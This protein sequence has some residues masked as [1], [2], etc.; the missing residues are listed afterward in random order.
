MKSG[1]SCRRHGRRE[2]GKAMGSEQSKRRGGSA[3]VMDQ[4]GARLIFQIKHTK[5]NQS[6][7]ENAK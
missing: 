4:E 3:R 6:P 5:Q 2:I 7:V 1:R